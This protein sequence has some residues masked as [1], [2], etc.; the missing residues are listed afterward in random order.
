MAVQARGEPRTGGDT[1]VGDV[2]LA[3]VG[4][5]LADAGRC[6]VLLALGDRR[7]LPASRLAAEAG[8]TPATASSHLAKLVAGGLLLVERH[9]R[10]RFYRLSGPKVGRLIEVLAELAPAQP[11]RSLRQ[12]SRAQALRDART[13]YDHL[14][15][16]LG[17]AV[18]AGML[19]RGYL[20]GGDGT[21][22]PGRAFR[23]RLNALGSDV[24]YRLTGAG[25]GC[26]SDLGVRLGSA[27]PVIRY[28]IDWSEQHHHLS[29]MV[30]RQLLDRLVE[31]D[32]VRRS[33]ASRAVQV[34]GSG[35]GGLASTFGITWPPA[36]DP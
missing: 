6:K 10:H 22:D 3:A 34:T 25:R 12:G 2:D 26:M 27:P 5:L 36:A 4:A 32:W 18:M 30:G 8:V 21:F 7:A 11:V 24:D 23:D 33:D 15:G 17:V 28:C 20:C 9:G 19:D 1:H 29:G 14:A 16:R 35:R 13:C 31:L